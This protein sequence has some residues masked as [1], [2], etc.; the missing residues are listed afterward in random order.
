MLYL[1]RF[2]ARQ[3][4]PHVLRAVLHHSEDLFQ[5]AR[6]GRS[7][8]RRIFADAPQLRYDVPA[9]HQRAH[10]HRLFKRQLDCCDIVDDDSQQAI[11]RCGHH[12]H[13]KHAAFMP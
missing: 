2:S 6:Q 4:F 7:Q 3:A 10:K 8:R 9:Q 11:Q 5:K 13:D 12:N 1:F